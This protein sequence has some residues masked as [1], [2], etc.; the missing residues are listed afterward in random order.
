LALLIAF[1]HHIA[2]LVQVAN[3]IDRV[4]CA[5]ERVIDERHPHAYGAGANGGARSPMPP[6]PPG[7]VCSHVTGFVQQVDVEGLLAHPALHD[8]HLEL[9]AR[10]GDFVTPRSTLARVWPAYCV[11]PEVADALRAAYMRDAARDVRQ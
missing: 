4:F 2:Q 7:Q 8:L 9:C 3:I 11:T 5:T 10:P 1:V 6:G